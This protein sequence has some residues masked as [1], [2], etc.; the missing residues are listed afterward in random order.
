MKA[1]LDR[2]VIANA[3]ETREQFVQKMESDR[4]QLNKP[5]KKR[6]FLGPNRGRSATTVTAP[7][8][9]DRKRSSTV[10]CTLVVMSNI[11]VKSILC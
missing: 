8:S 4:Q 9:A 5:E 3:K 11:H 6:S 2:S 10:T 7:K 1:S